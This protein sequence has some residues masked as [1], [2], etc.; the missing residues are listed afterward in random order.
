MHTLNT[1]MYIYTST[2]MRFFSSGNMLEKL[3]T[4]PLHWFC[5]RL[6]WFY[7]FSITGPWQV[8]FLPN[9]QRKTLLSVIEIDQ[10]PLSSAWFSPCLN[11]LNT[12]KKTMSYWSNSDLDNSSPLCLVLRHHSPYRNLTGLFLQCTGKCGVVR[13]NVGKIQEQSHEIFDPAL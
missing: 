10:Y 8:L 2:Y 9:P 6:K 13:V 12:V 1:N 4:I 7:Y 3:K 5:R 11:S